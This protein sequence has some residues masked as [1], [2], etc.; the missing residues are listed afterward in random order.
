MDLSRSI[1]RLI[2][3]AQALC[4]CRDCHKISGS[5]FAFNLIIPANNFKVLQGNPKTYTLV[6]NSGNDVTSHFCSD[7]GTTLFRDGPA[8]PGVK[9]VKAGI[10]DDELA[11]NAAKPSV[12]LFVSRKEDWVPAISDAFQKE[13]M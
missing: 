6:A 9:F 5:T 11:I 1:P 10:L 8:S 2:F 13:E 7:C 12:E 3:V 4:H